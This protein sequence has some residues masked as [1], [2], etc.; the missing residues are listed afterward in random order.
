MSSSCA[1]SLP[2]GPRC[3]AAA[4][5]ARGARGGRADDARDVA[6]SRSPSRPDRRV[7]PWATACATSTRRHCRSTRAVIPGCMRSCWLR[8]PRLERRSR[9]SPPRR[10]LAATALA[11]VGR[12][13]AGHDRARPGHRRDGGRC[14]RGE[15]LARR[16]D[17]RSALP[18]TAVPG[19]VA[20]ARRRRRR[21]GGGERRPAER[22]RDRLAALGSVQRLEHGTRRHAGL[23]RQLHAGSSFPPTRRRCC[24]SRRPGVLCSGAPR[25]STC[26]PTT[27]GSRPCTPS[28]SPTADRTLPADPLLPVRSAGRAATGFARTS[29]SRRSSTRTWSGRRSPSG[30]PRRLPTV[31]ST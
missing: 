24:G 20:L 18:G 13:V 23:G 25:R 1:S 11:A 12:R 3:G 28:R 31:S 7:E 9:S 4:H 14:A 10:P 6:V 5:A 2:L 26:S 19:A 27:G 22:R 8:S 30:S 15:P 21:V 29:R 17:E 16:R